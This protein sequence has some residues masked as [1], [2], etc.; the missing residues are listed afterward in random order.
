MEELNNLNLPIVRTLEFVAPS[1]HT[2]KIREQDGD[3]DDILSNPTKSKTLQNLSD[4]VSGIIVSNTRTG[5]RLN[6]EQVHKLP[7]LDRYAILFQ[8]RIF[9]LGQTIDFVWDWTKDFGGEQTYEQDL[10]E[11]LFDYS[12]TPDAETLNSKPYAIPFYPVPDCE[13]DIELTLTSGKTVRFDLMTPEGESYMIAL[14]VKTK[15]IELKAR[16]I[17]LLVKDKFEMVESFKVFSVKDMLEIRTKVAQVDPVF[18]GIMD[19][20][21][22]LFPDLKDR[23]NI[24]SIP[25]FFYLGEI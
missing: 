23:V 8:S 2:Y 21:N 25:S 10:R 17:R 19:L 20:D 6:S 12:K 14:P 16:N 18:T 1:G 4:F 24:I 7:S 15:N 5:G 9:S 22:P 11:F 13:T 3:D